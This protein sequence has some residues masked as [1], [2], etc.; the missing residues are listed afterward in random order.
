MI[1]FF[2]LSIILKRFIQFVVYNN[3]SFF[4]KLLGSITWYRCATFFFNFNFFKQTKNSSNYCFFKKQ[5]FRNHFLL[6]D[7]WVDYSCFWL[8]ND[9]AVK[10]VYRF[11]CG[12]KFSFL[13]NVY[14][15]MQLLGH[16]IV[17]SLVILGNWQIVF[18]INRIPDLQHNKWENNP[19]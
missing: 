3:E 13:W 8:T 19:K 9:A 18:N 10:I 16:M 6:K 1:G 11:L 15:G 4:F 17:A 12:H 2:S 14:S 5:F 7:I